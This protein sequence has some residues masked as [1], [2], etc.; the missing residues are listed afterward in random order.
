MDRDA[1]SRR[2]AR[3]VLTNLQLQYPDLLLES[4]INSFDKRLPQA[5]SLI[6][7]LALSNLVAHHG[8]V[9]LLGASWECQSVSRVGRQQG[10]MDPRFLFF[11]DMVR[12]LN[13]FQR[14]QTSAILYILENTH[15]G[16][17]CPLAVTKAG[18]LVQAFLGAPIVVD[19][20]DLGAATH[21]VRL[22]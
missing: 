18:N 12:I 16:E 2:I 19:A 4:A 22:F 9:D 3:H 17:R 5:V 13:F 21:R 11:Y 10:A 6:S 1:T 7:T 15:P 20:A 8:P 14:E